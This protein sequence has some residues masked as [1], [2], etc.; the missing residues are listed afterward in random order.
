MSNPPSVRRGDKLMP[1]ERARE[2]LADGYS[3]RLGTVGEDGYPYV[4]PLLYV[5]RDGRIYVH[6]TRVRG[7]LRA[8]VDR[9]PR[10]CFEVDEPGDV[11]AY[12]RFECDSSVAYRSVIAFGRIEVVDDAATKQ[13]FCEA[14]MAKYAPGEG[15]RPKGFFPRLDQ[16]TVYAIAVERLTGKETPLPAPTERWPAVDR[17]KTP[18]AVPPADR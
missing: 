13:R 7:H 4:V 9:E 6:N 2:M 3:G 5:W 18:R 1:D 16:I 8:N 14:L 17:T 10:V 15:G 12:G 11:F